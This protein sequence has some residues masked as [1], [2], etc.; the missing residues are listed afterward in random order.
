MSG[1]VDTL[2]LN[3]G[4]LTSSYYYSKLTNVYEY[5]GA[6]IVISNSCRFDVCMLTRDQ[7]GVTPV[8]QGNIQTSPCQVN[9]EF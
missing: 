5:S 9:I 6:N 4:L 8:C 3:E 1:A 7:L 2:S